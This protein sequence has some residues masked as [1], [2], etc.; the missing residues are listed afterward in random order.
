MSQATMPPKRRHRAGPA[1]GPAPA[2]VQERGPELPEETGPVGLRVRRILETHIIT[3]VFRPGEHLSESDLAERLGVSRQPVREAL[4][5]LSEAGLVRVLPQRGTEV[6][7]ISPARAESA[8]F[9]R[10]AV[11]GAIVREAAIQ[12]SPA[13][14]HQM[15]ALIRQQAAAVRAKNHAG[16]LALDDALHRAF[17]ASIAQE[18]VWRVLHTV[19]LQMDRVRYLSMPDAT[20]TTRLLKQHSAIVDAIERHAPDEAETM[21]HVHLSE[22]LLSLPRLMATMPDYF[23]IL[24]PQEGAKSKVR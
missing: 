18:D 13:A 9:L 1:T 23:E 11:E 6:T 20:P 19:K 16:F 5:R 21:L 17:A 2:L 4:I 8:R 3:N 10:A 24:D 22:L 7:R 12:A 15:R 14:I